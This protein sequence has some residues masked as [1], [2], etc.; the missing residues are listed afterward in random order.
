METCKLI[1]EIVSF[2]IMGGFAFQLLLL[3]FKR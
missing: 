1:I 3:G 2:G